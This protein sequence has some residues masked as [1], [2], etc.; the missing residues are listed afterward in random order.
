MNLCI[1][2]YTKVAKKTQHFSQTR[3]TLHDI[4]SSDRG[5][6]AFS[7]STRGNSPFEPTRITAPGYC[8]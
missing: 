1:I 5:R 4:N 2:P 6:I 7:P 8:S 3:D